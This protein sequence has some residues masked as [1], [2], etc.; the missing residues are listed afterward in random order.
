MLRNNATVTRMCVPAAEAALTGGDVLEALN[1]VIDE[2]TDEIIPKYRRDYRAEARR[3][4]T[5]AV[6]AYRRFG[7]A[8]LTAVLGLIPPH[9]WWGMDGYDEFI[10]LIV[11]LVADPPEPETFE[12]RAR[13]TPWQ[14]S[15]EQAWF[16]IN[17]KYDVHRQDID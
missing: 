14:L 2:I 16:L 15:D 3:T 10:D 1:S 13:S 17:G 9:D 4:A 7:L 12:H 11:Q 5:Q 8:G 6:A